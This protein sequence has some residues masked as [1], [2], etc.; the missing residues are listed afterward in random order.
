MI[1]FP[2]YHKEDGSIS[3]SKY[4]KEDG[5]ISNDSAFPVILNGDERANFKLLDIFL[6]SIWVDSRVGEYI[7]NLNAR[8]SMSPLSDRTIALLDRPK[9]EEVHSSYLYLL[10]SIFPLNREVTFS[11]IKSKNLRAFSELKRGLLYNAI[12]PHLGIACEKDSKY[13]QRCQEKLNC[14]ILPIL[15][16]QENIEELAQYDIEEIDS[17]E[18]RREKRRQNLEGIASAISNRFIYLFVKPLDPVIDRNEFKDNLYTHFFSRVTECI[19]QLINKNKLNRLFIE[20]P[21]YLT[22]QDNGV[23]SIVINS[24]ALLLSSYKL[25]F[26]TFIGQSLSHAID[27]SYFFEQNSMLMTEIE[28]FIDENLHKESNQEIGEFENRYALISQKIKNFKEKIE[29]NE[30]SILI[31]NKHYSDSVSE[32]DRL[33][34]DEIKGKSLISLQKKLKKCSEYKII[35]KYLLGNIFNQKKITMFQLGKISLINSLI[36]PSINKALYLY[37]VEKHESIEA[38]KI[39]E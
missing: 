16:E 19:P 33:L 10:D 28:H 21:N 4:R 37:L 27:N 23:H 7:N 30:A 38:R 3:F 17:A 36:S 39:W 8:L 34:V 6:M 24:I 1:S 25:A 12:H 5:G 20:I 32:K 31:E 26:I 35:K 2:E 15:I 14:E 18:K 22:S 9:I 13:L 11:T 29:E